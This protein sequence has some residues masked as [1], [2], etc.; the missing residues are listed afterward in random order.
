MESR[1]YKFR[2][3]DDAS[4]CW[5]YG[6]LIVGKSLS[7]EP[8]YQIENSDANE[9]R[10]WGVVPE[11][12]GQY[13]GLNG[14]DGKEIYSGDIVGYGDNYPCEIKYNPDECQYLAYEYGNEDG[15]RIHSMTAY[16]VK[17]KVLGNFY[18]NPELITK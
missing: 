15:L 17:W 18:E 9:F 5:V 1:I 13:I 2:G 10:L 16:T 6:N 11:S 8:F 7:G 4:K 3:F 12:V 14:I